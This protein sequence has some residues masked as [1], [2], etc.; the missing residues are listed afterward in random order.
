MSVHQKINI[1][2]A[3]AFVEPQYLTS[4]VIDNRTSLYQVL[5][6]SGILEQTDA[7]VLRE[8][9]SFGIYG[10]VV[11]D[12]KNYYLENGDRIEVYCPLVI[13]PKHARHLRAGS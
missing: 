5:S 13:D 9:L 2:L 3:C 11:A 10:Q 7:Y 6:A 4:M 8:Q 1:E 12:P